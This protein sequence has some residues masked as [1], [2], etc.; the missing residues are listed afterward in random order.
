MDPTSS[1]GKT[2]LGKNVIKI[3]SDKVEG[4]GNWSCPEYLDTANSGGKKET[5]A[6]IFHKID[7]EEISDRFVA[8]WLVNGLE[9]YDGEIN[10]GVEENMISN[11]FTVKL[12]LDHEV[13]LDFGDILD[14]E[15]V[16]VSQFV[17]KMGKS[18]RTKR[19]QLE[20]YKLTYSDVGPSMSTRK[21]LSP[22][23][24]E[25]EA[26]A[27]SICKRY[28]PLEE[29]RPVIKTMA[30]SDKYKKILKRICLDKIKLEGMDKA[31]EEALMKIKREALIEKDD[32]G[33][34][35]I[36][37]RLEGKIN[38]NALADTGSDIN[39]RYGLTLIS[40]PVSANALRLILPSSRKNVIKISSDK[41]EGHGDWSCPEYLDTANSGGK[42]ETKAMI[43]H[44]IDTEEISDRFVAR[45]LVNGLEAYDGEINLGVEE[46]MISNEFAVK[47]CLD[48]EVQR[49]NKVV[50]KELIVAL[51]GEI[52]FVKFILNPEE[53][54]VEPGVVFGRSFLPNT[55]PDPTESDSD[56]EEEYAFQ[57]NKFRAPIYGLN[58][59]RY[60]NRSDPLDRSLASQEVMNSYKKICVWKKVVSFLGLLPAALQHVDLKP[61]YT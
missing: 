49:G 28:S 4:H 47:L 7:T 26:L 11:E 58:P 41:V 38:L 10:L 17:C 27:I 40:E 60:L 37:I 48:H 16:D 46:N 22:E 24:A 54:D 20:N 35:V 51:R 15:G 56:D 6:M 12:C 61:D 57:R 1:I 36:P 55:S 19:K 34:F 33:A 23:E 52:Y 42:K 8:R 21:P 53:D 50:K 32:P 25:R 39:T 13:N 29:E 59:A 44:K 14:I 5:K 9:A 30:Y 31:D 2:C 45:W 43:F 3:S 18:S